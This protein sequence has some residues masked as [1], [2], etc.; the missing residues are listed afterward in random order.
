MFSFHIYMAKHHS[1]SEDEA[2][3][4]RPTRGATRLRQL[5]IRIAKGQKTPV[6]I[7][8]NIEMPRGPYA[9]VL[10]SNLGMLAREK[11][12]ILTPSFDHVTEVD[13]NMI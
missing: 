12:S 3:T 4:K 6:D 7:N 11:I 8:V 5:L 1:S 2:L 13:R 10:K 9:D